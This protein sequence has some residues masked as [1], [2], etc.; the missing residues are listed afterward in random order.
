MRTAGPG[1]TLAVMVALSF[2][3]MILLAASCGPISIVR[4]EK[5]TVLVTRIV[6]ETMLV[7]VPTEKPKEEPQE[8][9]DVDR[10]LTSLAEWAE[11]RGRTPEAEWT[12]P[13]PVRTAL[14]RGGSGSAVGTVVWNDA[15]IQGVRVKLCQQWTQ[16]MVGGE[17]DGLPVRAF[18]E[19]TIAK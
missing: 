18:G 7:S 19:L 1:R 17:H 11:R 3:A 16:F 2:L 12:P 5:Q 8:K 10:V 9:M 14:A 15:P 13:P 6:R 4:V